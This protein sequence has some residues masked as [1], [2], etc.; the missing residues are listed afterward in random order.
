MKAK[1]LFILST[2]LMILLL[3]VQGFAQEITLAEYLH[4]VEE[5]HPFF[6]KEALSAEIERKQAEGLLGAEDWLVGVSP[7]FNYL[8]E[9]SAAQYSADRL[10][11]TGAQASLDRS[12][13]STGGKLG[14]SVVSDFT[15]MDTAQGNV[16]NF[17]Q[18]IGVSYTQ[19]LLKNLGGK[20]DRLGHELSAYSID[21]TEIQALENQET[22]ILDLSVRFLGW[23]HLSEMIRIAEERLKLAREQLEQVKRRFSS[24]LVDRV[25]VLR[26]ED[27]VR[28]AE[29]GLLQLRSQWRAKQAELAVLAQVGE[30][31]EKVPRFELYTFESLPGVDAA[32]SELKQR[33]RILQPFSIL[34]KQLIHQRAGLVEQKRPELNLILSGGFFGWDPEF[35]Q[36][37]LITK[38]DASVSLEF[39]ALLGNR[40]ITAEME[41]IDIQLQRLQAES[42]D[43]EITLEAS[44]RN[45]LLQM[46]DM[47]KILELNQAQIESAQEKTKEELKLYNQGRGQ[48]TFVIQSRDNEQN[49][50]LSYVDNAALYHL[51][52]LQY[53]ALLDKLYPLK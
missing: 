47:G 23:A 1:Q 34:K 42:R 37:L 49:A 16:R 48:L 44:L 17:K 35:L 32:V 25:D 12:L 45:L 46:A 33:S 27:A 31:Y 4:F 19:P 9:A 20:L 10:A 13:W 28:G 11:S 6:T 29:Q 24:N 14:F 8:G 53:Q 36:S 39:K 5:N 15:Y 2:L 38:P 21:V 52:K 3:A 41:V 30:I 26:G 22:L 51:L 40:G 18:G 43:L 7:Y 50:R